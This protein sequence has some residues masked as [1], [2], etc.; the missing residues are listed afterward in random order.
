MHW[1]IISFLQLAEAGREGGQNAG[2]ARRFTV[3][4]VSSG[5]GLSLGCGC[6]VPSGSLRLP[7]MWLRKLCRTEAVAANSHLG[8]S[9]A[10]P[11]HMT[12]LDSSRHIHFL[13][14][15]APCWVQR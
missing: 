3:P 4:Q 7:S 11:Q 8:S 9:K 12:G 15:A 5:V 10:A 1:E 2:E 13:E 14:A 6:L